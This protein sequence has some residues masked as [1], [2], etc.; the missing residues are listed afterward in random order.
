MVAHNQLLTPGPEVRRPLLASGGT[1]HMW[2][3]DIHGGATPIHIKE[4]K[5]TTKTK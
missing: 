3:K 1:A 4:N 5:T 2:C